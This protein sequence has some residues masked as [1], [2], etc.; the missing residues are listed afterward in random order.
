MAYGSPRRYA[1][2][3]ALLLPDRPPTKYRRP[4]GL[5]PGCSH[6]FPAR[7]CCWRL[8]SHNAEELM[9]RAP[10]HVAPP[11]V[12]RFANTSD[13]GKQTSRWTAFAS[14]IMVAQHRSRYDHERKVPR[15][16]PQPP[17]ASSHVR[18]LVDRG[19]MSFSK[20]DGA[21]C[22]QPQLSFE[23]MAINYNLS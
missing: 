17:T 9:R 20:L 15:R 12:P 4:V 11:R 7:C 23:V 14:C 13:M 2:P 18:Y 8:W 6:P 22:C 19:S 3:I 5:G 10:P 21:C 1:N 16:K